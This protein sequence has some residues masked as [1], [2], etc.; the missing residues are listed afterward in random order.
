MFL[1]VPAADSAAMQLLL[2][3]LQ[4]AFR[5]FPSFGLHKAI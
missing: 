1:H 3:L 4:A 2:L 5:A